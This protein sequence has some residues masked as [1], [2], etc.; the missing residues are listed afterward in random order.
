MYGIGETFYYDIEEYEQEFEVIGD[1]MTKGKEYII[2]E[3]VNEQEKYVFLYDDVEEISIL[4]DDEDEAERILNRWEDQVYGT[5]GEMDFW[6][7]D[8]Y[9]EREDNIDSEEKYDEVESFGEF[10]EDEESFLGTISEKDDETSFYG[11]LMD[12]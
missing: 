9:Y 7:D 6:D 3:E 11:G 1:V 12:R 4:I 10:E 5:S 2:A 8:E